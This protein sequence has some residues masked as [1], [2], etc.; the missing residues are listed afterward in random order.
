MD[1]KLDIAGLARAEQG[2]MIGRAN[3]KLIRE[4]NGVLANLTPFRGPSADVGTA[5]EV[6]FARALGKAIVGYTFAKEPYRE[7]V[8]RSCTPI[9][10]RDNGVLEDATGM[11]I[12]DFDMV[13]NLMLDSAILESGGKILV[14]GEGVDPFEVFE[15]AALVM[16]D[17]LGRSRG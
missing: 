2:R 11:S 13:D 5:F 14:P 9:R 16:A 10:K 12:E 15:R 6:G 7:R 17:I 8:L 3:E 4:S 1:V